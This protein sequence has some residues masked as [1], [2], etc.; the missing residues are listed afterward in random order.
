MFSLFALYSGYSDLWAAGRQTDV[1]GYNNTAS[2]GVCH[3][4]LVT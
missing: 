4:G 2:R 3:L 1:Q